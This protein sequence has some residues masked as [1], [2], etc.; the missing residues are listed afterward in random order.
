VIPFTV[1]GEFFRFT[2]T[3]PATSA[4][5]VRHMRGMQLFYRFDGEL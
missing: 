2:V 3:F 1:N 5:A 4:G